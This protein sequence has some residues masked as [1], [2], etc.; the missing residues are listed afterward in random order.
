MWSVG[1][2]KN[3][4]KIT[5]INYVRSAVINSKT[6]RLQV[7]NLVNVD[8]CLWCYRIWLPYGAKDGR[9]ASKND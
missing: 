7:S 6:K 2:E 5:G 9:A 3:I 8:H 4:N 1:L